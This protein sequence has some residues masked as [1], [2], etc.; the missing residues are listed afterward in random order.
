MRDYQDDSVFNIF[1][2]REQGL[3]KQAPPKATETIDFSPTWLLMVW[4]RLLRYS[5]MRNKGD[6][7][8]ANF[9][10]V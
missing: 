4:L 9:G 5:Q 6:N 2:L 7:C 8:A 3:R 10:K 1:R